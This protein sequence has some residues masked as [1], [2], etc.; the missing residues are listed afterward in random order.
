MTNLDKSKDKRIEIK[1]NN[2][3][4]VVLSS[5]KNIKSLQESDTITDKSFFQPDIYSDISSNNNIEI[6]VDNNI[7][8]EENIS[9]SELLSKIKNRTIQP[10]FTDSLPTSSVTTIKKV[11]NINN[12]NSFSC[13]NSMLNEKS[14]SVSSDSDINSILSNLPSLTPLKQI[15][16]DNYCNN[17]SKKIIDVERLRT[18]NVRSFIMPTL[19]SLYNNDYISTRPD[20]DENDKVNTMKIMFVCESGASVDMVIGRLGHIGVG[21]L[22]GSVNVIALESSKFSKKTDEI[23]EEVD[24]HIPMNPDEIDEQE[25]E[26]EDKMFY[27][28]QVK[29]ELN[30]L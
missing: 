22:V 24:N 18:I 20:I 4:P 8:T 30:K 28:L 27:K 2:T 17:E 19:D 21:T 29:L 13:N 23:N 6:E 14:T 16:S 15:S 12:T 3:P 7:D 9:P 1:N 5:I 25:E 11:S 26:E 10:S